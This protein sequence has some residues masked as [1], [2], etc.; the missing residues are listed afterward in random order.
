MI[1]PLNDAAVEVGALLLAVPDAASRASIIAVSIVEQIPECACAIHRFSAENGDE[2]WTV[3]GAAGEISVERVSM[4][5]DNR[6]IASLF[7]DPP[8]SVICPAAKIRRE[9]YSHLNVSRSIASIAYVP[10]FRDAH[11]V[12]AIE[13]LSFATILRSQDLEAIAPIT[14]LAA[15][16]ILAA[17]DTELQRQDLLDSVHRMSQLYDLEKSLN[18][19][20]ELDAVIA[21]IPVKVLAML[22]CQAIHLWLFDG[23]VLRLVSSSGD[24]ATVEV[25]TTQVAGEG[26]R[27]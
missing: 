8:Q 25:G 12:G 26:L 15:P 3:I 18:S 27:R 7:S 2:S 1:S 16:A 17:E 5:A 21:S 23:E 22:P 11:L 9:D 6:L 4:Q 19:T 24:D 10:L 14:Q 20:L 13:I